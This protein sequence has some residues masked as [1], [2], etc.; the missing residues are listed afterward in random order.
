[1]GTFLCLKLP[2]LEDDDMDKMKSA[3]VKSESTRHMS[4]E[5]S[6]VHTMT[7][8][9]CITV[10]ENVAENSLAFHRDECM[11]AVGRM[12]TYPQSFFAG[13]LARMIPIEI[14]QSEC[15]GHIFTESQ[16]ETCAS[17]GFHV[18]QTASDSGEELD[19]GVRRV[20][21]LPCLPSA[22]NMK[23][24]DGLVLELMMPTAGMGR[25]DPFMYSILSG[26][27][28]RAGPHYTEI[29]IEGCKAL[30]IFRME[31]NGKQ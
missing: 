13:H 25:V 18:S 22:V 11:D 31:S 9:E 26:L 6:L 5:S 24:H 28:T 10:K 20:S 27:G 29:A 1:M 12:L 19:A 8:F 14:G 30:F 23:V 2:G 16:F 15:A 21:P 7:F 17:V 3:D 4:D